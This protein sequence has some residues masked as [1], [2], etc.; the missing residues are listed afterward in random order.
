MKRSFQR[1]AVYDL[2]KA[3]TNDPTKFW[4]QIAELGPRKKHKIPWEILND[5]GSIDNNFDN[6]MNKWRQ[7]FEDLLNPSTPL[8]PEEQAFL[9]SVMDENMSAEQMWEND[10][11]IINAE[12][13]ASIT[14]DEVARAIHKAKS[15]KAPG[16]DGVVSETLRNNVSI[17]FLCQ[18]FNTCMEKSM[19]PSVW[20][21]GLITPIPKTSKGDP[22]IPTNYRGISLLSMTGKLYTSIIS[23]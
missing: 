9:N 15:G 23:K 19:M 13:N 4:K 7:D 11:T 17:N 8:G 3:N 21:K 5:D 16:I 2:E 14:K 22:R 12:L 6:I 18:L 10:P 1:Q 20:A